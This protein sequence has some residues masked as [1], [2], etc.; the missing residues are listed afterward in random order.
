[1]GSGVF[2]RV[3]PNEKTDYAKLFTIQ[4]NGEKN[5]SGGEAIGV[6]GFCTTWLSC[7]GSPLTHSVLEGTLPPDAL[8]NKQYAEGKCVRG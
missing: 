7:P 5:A 8:S 2:T 3:L 6:R 4:G 1:V